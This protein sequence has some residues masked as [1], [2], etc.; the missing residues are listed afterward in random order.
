MEGEPLTTF[1]STHS[2]SS[3]I[4]A[5]RLE[6]ALVPTSASVFADDIAILG[7]IG[8]DGCRNR[9][10]S[11]QGGDQEALQGM[12]CGGRCTLLIVFKG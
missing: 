2:G 10:C 4:V 8:I 3:C 6:Y 7:A 5:V 1:E 9:K 12:H 11:Q